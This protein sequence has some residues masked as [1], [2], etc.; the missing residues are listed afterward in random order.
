MTGRN[1]IGDFVRNFTG[2]ERR[3]EWR[4]EEERRERGAPLITVHWCAR[5]AQ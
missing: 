2:E 4:R 5:V 3:G 1:S